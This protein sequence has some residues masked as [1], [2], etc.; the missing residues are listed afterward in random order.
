MK[1][2]SPDDCFALPRISRVTRRLRIAAAAAMFGSVAITTISIIALTIIATPLLA[3]QWPPESVTPAPIMQ[4]LRLPA[5]RS[6]PSTERWNLV[7]ADQLRPYLLTEGKIDFAA[8][9][10]VGSQKLFAAQAAQF[11]DVNPDF[12]VLTYHLAAGLNPGRNDDCPDPK[13]LDGDGHIGVVA[14]EGYVSEWTTH[15]LPWLLAEGIPVGSARFEDMFQHYDSVASSTRVWHLDPYWLMNLDNTDW[16]RYCGDICLDWM[17][18]NE[19]E[20]CFFDVAVE[21]NAFFYNPRMQNPPPGDFDWWSAPHHPTQYAGTF[22]DRR[23]FADWMNAQYRGYFQELYRRF[24]EG[25]TDRL[26]IPNVDQMVT[27]VYDPVWL[28]GGTGGEAVDGVMMEGFGNYRGYDM[29]LTLERCVRHVTGRGK[30]LLAQFSQHDA[31]ERYRRAAMYMLV[32][33][34]NSFINAVA[35]DVRWYPE[36]EID[37]G[38]QSRLPATLDSLRA[39]GSG[40]QSLWRRDYAHGMVL[41]NTGDAAVSYPLP[42]GRTWAIVRT[43]GGGE[44]A[45]DGTPPPLSITTLPAGQT[46]QI[47]PSEGL[48][49]A[50]SAPTGVQEPDASQRTYPAAPA[51]DIYPQPAHDVLHLRIT[52]PP[53]ATGTIVLTTLLGRSILTVPLAGE[54]SGGSGDPRGR[55][56]RIALPPLPSGVYM[57]TMH[58]DRGGIF[59]R[60]VLVAD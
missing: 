31:A 30:I 46:V 39:A 17:Q 44:V 59:G 36:Y 38:A 41:V 7:W 6:I 55:H 18:G 48:I 42:G 1:R 20:G 47:E 43:D 11:R 26:V 3:Q 49:L 53:D 12:L 58:F 32:K 15:F 16:R 28:D 5:E 24:H 56:L 22:S 57:L 37:L 51:V 25:S 54:P 21:T 29:Y 45:D 40:P 19:N 23:A 2:I 8:R 10:Y 4:H 14:P 9:H 34:A 33:N 50:A 52:D 27:S 13:T 35:E 60:P